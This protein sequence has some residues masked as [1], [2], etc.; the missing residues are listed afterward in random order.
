MALL[1]PVRPEWLRNALVV[2][3]GILLYG[4]ICVATVVGILWFLAPLDDA[5][6]IAKQERTEGSR[7]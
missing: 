5:S 2:G 7:T 4:A 1:R 3:A 6:T